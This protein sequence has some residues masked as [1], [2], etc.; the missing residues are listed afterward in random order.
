MKIA[1]LMSQLKIKKIMSVNLQGEILKVQLII[2]KL[3]VST[4][5][6][7]RAQKLGE[8]KAEVNL[9]INKKL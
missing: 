3:Q 7:P 5:H 8:R 9:K 4:P 6:L 2:K 1:K